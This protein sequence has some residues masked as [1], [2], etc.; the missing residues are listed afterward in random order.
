MAL[1]VTLLPLLQAF[2][3]KS[4]KAEVS[5]VSLLLSSPSAIYLLCLGIVVVNTVFKLT[6]LN[7]LV[8]PLTTLV[9][10]VI[11][12]VFSV[13]SSQWILRIGNV[14]CVL[15]GVKSVKI[16]FIVIMS[17]GSWKN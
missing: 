13:L 11:A 6:V 10:F 12:K 9:N 17:G 14:L 4:H 2:V 5:Q 7:F 15:V 8:D 16:S 1:S 3:L